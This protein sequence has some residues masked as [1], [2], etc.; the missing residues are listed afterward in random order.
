MKCNLRFKLKAFH[1]P[2]MKNDFY[3]DFQFLFREIFQNFNS[4]EKLQDF[5]YE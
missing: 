1:S 3:L 2:Y 5:L 4:D